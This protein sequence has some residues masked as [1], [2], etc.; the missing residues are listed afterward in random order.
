MIHPRSYARK[1][2]QQL[3]FNDEANLSFKAESF[4]QKLFSKDA[5]VNATLLSYP[6]PGAELNLWVYDSKVGVSVSLML[7]SNIQ[8]ELVAFYSTKL[9]KPQRNWPAYDLVLFVCY[10]SVLKI[11]THA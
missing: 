2:A 1:S 9:N 4:L 5:F 6:I 10:S 11:L 7:L 8:W 3:E